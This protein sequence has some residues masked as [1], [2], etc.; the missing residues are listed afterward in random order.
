MGSYSSPGEPGQQ[1][2]PHSDSGDGDQ[3]AGG[4]RPFRE[5]THGT[6]KWMGWRRKREQSQ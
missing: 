3:C 6:W 5:E 1:L 2:G 4:K